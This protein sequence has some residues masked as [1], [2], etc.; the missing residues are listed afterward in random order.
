MLVVFAGYQHF[1]FGQGPVQTGI[2][3]TFSGIPIPEVLDT[4]AS[5]YGLKIYYLPSENIPRDL[6]TGSFNN[7]TAD[8][9]IRTVLSKSSLQVIAVSD[10]IFF[11]TSALGREGVNMNRYLSTKAK[12]ENE[13]LPG[14]LVL[15]HPDSMPIQG[16]ARILGWIRNSR[17]ETPV[18]GAVVQI[19]D[20]DAVTDSAGKFTI[21]TLPGT[22]SL[23][24]ISDRFSEFNQN[25]KVFGDDHL[26]LNLFESTVDLPELVVGANARQKLQEAT[27]GLSQLSV[28]EI[29]RLP[30]LMG[31][32]DVVKALTTLPGVSTTGEVGSGYHVRG[33]NTDQNLVLQDG[34]AYLNTSHVLGLFSSFNADAINN[35]S[36][37]K[38]HIPARFGGRISSVLDIQLKDPDMKAWNFQGGLGPISSKVYLEGPV[39]KDKTSMLAGLRF[40]YSDWILRWLRD[41]NLKNSQAD[42]YDFSVKVNHRFKPG[43]VLS[44]STYASKD[45]FNYADQFGYGWQTLSFSAQWYLD[46]K[47][48]MSLHASAGRSSNRN[49]FT[50]TDQD[51]TE[52]RIGTGLGFNNAK[53]RLA[54]QISPSQFF[55]AGAEWTGYTPDDENY[56]VKPASDAATNEYYPKTRGRE[57]AAYIQLESRISPKLNISIGYRHSLYW[58]AG[59]ARI[60]MY[61]PGQPRTEE[62]VTGTKDYAKG[63][64]IKTYQGFEPRLSLAYSTGPQSSIKLSYNKMNQYIH[65][66]SNTAVATPV[67]IWQLSNQHIAP[68][69][70]NNYSLGFFKNLKDHRWETSLEFYFRNS[71]NELEYK[72]FARLLRNEFL[73]TEIFAVKGRSYGAEL[74]IKKAVGDFRGYLSY[75]LNR[76]LRKSEGLYPDEVINHGAF[77]ASNFDKPHAINALFD[78]QIRKTFSWSAR[79]VFNSGRPQTAPV[80][81]F[82]L[83]DGG[84]F[85]DYSERN[86]FRIPVYHRLDLSVTVTRGN[87]RTRK[88]KASWTFSI[89]NAY[90]RRNAFSVFYRRNVNEPPVAYKLS[91]LGAI[92]PSVTY[93]FR[94]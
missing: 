61:S 67:D 65:L 73:E 23:R 12:L 64:G 76:S 75:T 18:E 84:H 93:N 5:G 49:H 77:Y 87:I 20:A 48:G 40:S 60:R 22:Y 36:L 2:T 88:Y 15:G 31:E 72:D 11:L 63:S 78:W 38:G 37:Y 51:K 1:L 21:L 68:Q 8:E 42:F 71:R 26:E 35:V 74:F 47:P 3:R 32:A 34:V 45:L 28:K 14:G 91:V 66:I 92:L 4:L 50:E 44:L 30:S 69:R 80:A 9:A 19:G 27:S 59:P 41:P 70:G 56:R 58:Q 10:R 33:G 43:H 82:Y 29:Q 55:Q 90:N 39:V 25:L 17:D 86:E 85:F 24:V 16:P 57:A 52:Y 53:A 81:E 83:G 7:Q 89:Y 13:Y 6:F 46:L 79:F 94:F 62:S 54:W